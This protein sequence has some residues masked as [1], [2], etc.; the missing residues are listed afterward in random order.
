MVEG[1]RPA[2]RPYV[3]GNGFTL[4]V[5]GL[6][7]AQV[8]RQRG[9][10]PAR[11]PEGWSKGAGMTELEGEGMEGPGRL[12]R[13]AATPVPMGD[14]RDSGCSTSTPALRQPRASE[15]TW[16]RREVISVWGSLDH[17]KCPAIRRYGGVDSLPSPCGMASPRATT[18]ES[19]GTMA[20]AS[21]LTPCSWASPERARVVSRVSAARTWHRPLERACRFLSG[22]LP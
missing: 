20:L 10:I 9:W 5:G 1:R 2:S 17:Q 18:V 8:E 21:N 13:K 12:R 16:K 22:N 3:G 19:L 11:G 14:V 6:A 15:R 4:P 7:T